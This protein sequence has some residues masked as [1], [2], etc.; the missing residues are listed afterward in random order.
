MLDEQ[1][2]HNIRILSLLESK[3]C[4]YYEQVLKEPNT[5]IVIELELGTCTTKKIV[6]NEVVNEKKHDYKLW[7]Y[8]EDAK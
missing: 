5:K 2:F 4:K 8:G 3:L 7:L 6:D 1:K